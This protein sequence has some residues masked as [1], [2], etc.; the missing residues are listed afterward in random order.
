MNAFFGILYVLFSILFAAY[1]LRKPTKFNKKS[2]VISLC[3]SLAAFAVVFLG[4]SD[5]SAEAA[6]FLVQFLIVTA[7]LLKSILSYYFRREREET[8]DEI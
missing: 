7:V 4:N 5:F 6:F 8:D 1:A 2:S 3:A